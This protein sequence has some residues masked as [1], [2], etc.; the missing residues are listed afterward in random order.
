MFLIFLAF[1]SVVCYNTLMDKK[2]NTSNQKLFPY[3][4]TPVLITLC[5]LVLLLSCAGIAVSVYRLILRGSLDFKIGEMLKSPFLICVCL[6]CI[7]LIVSLL[8]KSQYILTEKELI[9]QFGFIK[10]KFELKKITS[11]S[12]D[13]NT[14]KLSVYFGEEFIVLTLMEI[15]QDDFVSELIKLNPDID[16]T[17]TITE[18]KPPEEK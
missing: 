6:F 8:I 2:N 13:R 15:W 4:L 9:T 7:L 16:F 11:I 1:F 14:H 10:S 5:V 12:L 17:Y 3:R 18:N